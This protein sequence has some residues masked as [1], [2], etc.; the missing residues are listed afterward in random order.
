MEVQFMENKISGRGVTDADKNRVQLDAE[1]ESVTRLKHQL[2][3][4][5][6]EANKMLD[7]LK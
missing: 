7:Q 5:N 3:L 6:E 1:R 4:K 2:E